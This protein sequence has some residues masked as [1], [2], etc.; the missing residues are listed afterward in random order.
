MLEHSELV[1]GLFEILTNFELDPL[2]VMSFSDAQGMILTVIL[3]VY[4]THGIMTPS[5]D[6]DKWRVFG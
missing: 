4:Q 1:L 3:T 5:G 6:Y 2:L